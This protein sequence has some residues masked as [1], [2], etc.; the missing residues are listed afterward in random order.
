MAQGSIFSLFGSELSADTFDA[1]SFPL[2]RQVNGVRV[3]VVAA[4]IVYEAPLLH[5]DPLQIN[6]I[7]PSDVPVGPAAV[8]VLR[9][10]QVSNLEPVKVV[11]WYPSLF[12][13]GPS[14]S[15]EAYSNYRQEAAGQRYVGVQPQP[16]NLDAPASPGGD[17]TLW[18]TGV[19]TAPGGDDRPVVLTN[20]ASS[21]LRALVGGKEA[22][23]TY[24]GP[25]GCCVGLAQLNIR[26]PLDV[27]LGCFVPVQLVGGGL[28]SNVA[29]IPI[30]EDGQ[31]CP[32]REERLTRVYL[33]RRDGDDDRARTF[34]GRE[35]Y[36][37]NE[38]PP[39]GSCQVFSQPQSVRV[40]G[41]VPESE[42][43]VIE[44][45]A[46]T[47]E[48]SEGGGPLRFA[49][50]GAAQLGSGL[51]D[52]ASTGSDFPAYEATLTVPSWSF[53]LSDLAAQT[54]PRSSGL[55]FT[56]GVQISTWSSPTKWA[57]LIT[58]DS[59]MVCSVDLLSGSFTV[60]PEI[61]ALLKEQVDWSFGPMA[62]VPI[63][64]DTDGP[65]TG[66][67]VYTDLTTPQHTDLGPPLLAASRVYLPG[68][69]FVDA[70]LATT[71]AERQRGLQYRTTLSA[72]RGM[73]FFFESP[74]PYGFWMSETLIPL[75]IFWLDADRRIV[76]ISADTPP[77]PS[78]V[79]CPI[80][81]PTVA[82]QYVLEL[83]AGEAARRG[84]FVGDQLSW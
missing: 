71:Q 56:W 18:A 47:F 34:H 26:V 81:S 8:R 42:R 80:Y 50:E 66:L 70:E 7:F 40:L 67:I 68:E 63:E 39:V 27:D 35:W 32:G 33:D 15:Q 48:L 29:T 13:A 65:E 28:P 4:G 73:L 24:Q 3:E 5:V 55:Q 60:G 49:P 44:G 74:G 78:G 58:V 51:Y 25:A 76:T 79:N 52:V 46:S 21:P 53:P 69:D 36:D 20:R 14:E 30:A 16:L 72:E 22:T 82:A 23:I 83:A 11:R 37:P 59:R 75:D 9:T 45:P 64:T 54:D 10:G 77:C 61:L 43:V 31:F 12:L 57:G 38:L 19:F 6:A 84:L 17:V 62:Y 41:H 1:D 2:P